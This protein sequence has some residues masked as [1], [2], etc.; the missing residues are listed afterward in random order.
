MT[1]KFRDLFKIISQASKTTASF[2]FTF[3]CSACR[4]PIDNF[5]KYSLCPECIGKIKFIKPPLC[6]SCGAELDSVLEICSKCMKAAPRPWSSAI[7]VFHMETFG[8]ELIHQFK[9]GNQI[10]LGRSLA[11]L[12]ANAIAS[13]RIKF[14]Y[15]EPIPLH[16]T[17]Q[18]T[19]G[20]N[21]SE[22]VVNVLSKKMMVKKSNFLKRTRNT[23][24]QASLDKAERKRNLIGAF[25]IKRE[26]NCKNRTILLVD[27]VMTTGA[28]LTEATKVLLEA[29]ASKVNILV[30]ARR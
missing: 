5:P 15:I 10:E 29:G 26:A 22:I 23:K 27:D 17:K 18:L 21:Q 13:S 4:K 30:L 1:I 24:Q 14:D 6:N 12:A 20:Y 19:R 28:T 9:Y 16:W 11:E 3:T 25:S 2:F 8:K 7:S